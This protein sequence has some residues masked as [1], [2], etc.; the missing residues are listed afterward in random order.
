M[1][2]AASAHA[3][4]YRCPERMTVETQ[5][6][7]SVQGFE[8]INSDETRGSH[9]AHFNDG[10]GFYSGHPR[11][12]ADLLPD[13]E[14]SQKGPWVWTTAKDDYGYWMECRYTATSLVYVKKIAEGVSSCKT[15]ESTTKPKKSIG[16]QCK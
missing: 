9:D 7:A 11:E 1:L 14:H 10:V 6:A 2:G 12:M 5:I 8:T 4:D 13:N 16:L 15:I 3:V